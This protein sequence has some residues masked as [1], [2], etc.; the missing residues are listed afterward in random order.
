MPHV[1][2]IGYVTLAVYMGFTQPERRTPVT[3]RGQTV[4]RQADREANNQE[5]QEAKPGWLLAIEAGEKASAADCGDAQTCRS[6]QR[7]YSDLRAQ[8]HAAEGTRGQLR[9]TEFQTW[10]AAVGTVLIFVALI[11]SARGTRA[12]IEANDINR[13]AYMA[14]QRP[15]LTVR[16]RV[17]SDL[18][19]VHSGFQIKILLLIKNVGKSPATHIFGDAKGLARD[20][21][22]D[23]HAEQREFARSMAPRGDGVG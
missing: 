15:W 18:T 5:S 10:I 12:A 7:N 11:Y 22:S 16:A 9:F 17:V 8:W 6:E 3:E 13:Q 4:E 20:E 23:V 14:D 19:H 1:T 2:L 21:S